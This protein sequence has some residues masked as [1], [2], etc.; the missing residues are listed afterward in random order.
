MKAE[1]LRIGNFV[2]YFG[3]WIQIDGIKRLSSGKF[4]VEICEKRPSGSS[5]CELAPIDSPS[6]KPIPLTEE[7]LERLGFEKINEWVILDRFTLRKTYLGVF[8]KNE[9]VNDYVRIDYIHQL[10]NLYYALTGAELTIK[11]K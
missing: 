1:E 9:V 6:L 8:Y 4:S 7:W 10:Q 11:I 3:K 2:E 5:W